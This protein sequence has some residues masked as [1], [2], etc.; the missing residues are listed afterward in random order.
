MRLNPSHI[1][2]L[3]DFI[4]IQASIMYQSDQRPI[5]ISKQFKDYRQLAI[6]LEASGEI[7]VGSLT[8]VVDKDIDSRLSSVSITG[9]VI[10]LESPFPPTYAKSKLGVMLAEG[11]LQQR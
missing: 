1:V 9:R 7:Y 2:S 5:H 6:N 4:Y 8:E 3:Y 10:R 11:E